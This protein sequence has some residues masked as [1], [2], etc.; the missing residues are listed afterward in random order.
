MLSV[1]EQDFIAQARLVGCSHLLTLFSHILPNMANTLIVLAT[2][3]VIYGILL[4]GS[5]SFLGVG[6]PPPTPAWGLMVATGRS[7]LVSAW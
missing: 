4:E 5:L 2:L 1:K 7:L 6:M 3:Q